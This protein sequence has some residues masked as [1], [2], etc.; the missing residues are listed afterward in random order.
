M[1]KQ[2]IQV[3]Q[4]FQEYGKFAESGLPD[5]LKPEELKDA[6]HLSA[7]WMKSSYVENQGG[8]K[9]AIRELPVQAQFAPLFGMIADDFDQA[10]NLDL[11]LSGNDY[12][13]EVSVGRYDAM[14]GLVL[15]G[16]GKGGFR[17]LSISESGYMA[18]G[19]MKGLV[20]LA[21]SDG[22]WLSVT[23]Q[24][25]ELLRFHKATRPM[26]KVA[27][28]AGETSV[29]LHLKNGKSRRDEPGY[30]SSFLSQSSHAL[31]LPDYVSAI[32]AIDSKG[33]KRELK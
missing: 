29:V 1:G 15:K 30:G 2:V 5:I 26:R 9:F 22:K 31:L 3:R 13:S 18:N 4:R 20:R 23:S 25:R 14:Y 24:N 10:G 7:T 21:S 33:N 16:D 27:L 8:G 12:G 19:N 32:T 11:M 6:L 17:P 28:A